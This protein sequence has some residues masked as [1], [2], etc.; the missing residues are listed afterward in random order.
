ML[1]RPTKCIVFHDVEHTRLQLS[2]FQLAEKLSVP[3]E[4]NKRVVEARIG[5]GRVLDRPIRW[6]ENQEYGAD[7]TSTG[8][9][10]HDM[11][12]TQGR[13]G[14]TKRTGYGGGGG[15]GGGRTLAFWSSCWRRLSI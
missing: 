11:S 2:V 14:N 10:W 1:D 7:T 9:R 6:R 4:S 12:F 8:G 13:Q 15:G 5:D 3:L